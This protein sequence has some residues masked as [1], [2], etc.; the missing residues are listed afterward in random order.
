[1]NHLRTF[2]YAVQPIEVIVGDKL[3]ELR[4]RLFFLHS[5]NLLHSAVF[6]PIEFDFPVHQLIIDL[7]PFV[8][9]QTA[10]QLHSKLAKLLLIAR[11][12][13]LRHQFAGIQILFDRQ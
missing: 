13:F 9:V 10:I 11:I 6:N 4:I 7:R 3:R 2:V 8:F 1:M 5:Q 12:C